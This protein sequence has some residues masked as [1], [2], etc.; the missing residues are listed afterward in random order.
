MT[1]VDGSCR[2]V[3]LQIHSFVRDVELIYLGTRARHSDDTSS[4]HTEMSAVWLSSYSPSLPI[5]AP[6]VFSAG[7]FVQ[8]TPIAPEERLAESVWLARNFD[9]AIYVIQKFY[10]STRKE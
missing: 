1:T 5:D 6:L 7:S 2:V 4:R 10:V 9:A 8:V 3:L